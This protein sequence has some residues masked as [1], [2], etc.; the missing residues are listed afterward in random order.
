MSSQS[1]TPSASSRLQR[2]LSAQL[3]SHFDVLRR[4]RK[5]FTT[6]VSAARNLSRLVWIQVSLPSEALMNG[7]DLQGSDGKK[8]KHV[9]PRERMTKEVL[10]A[11]KVRF[12][13]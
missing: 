10:R 1:D 7:K 8:G 3:T 13:K 9:G 5:D 4:G 6:L 11:E 12:L 2:A